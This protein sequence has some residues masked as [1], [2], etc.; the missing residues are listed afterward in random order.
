MKKLIFILIVGSLYGDT[1]VYR[2]DVL[3]FKR[4]KTLSDVSYV[5]VESLLGKP[6]IKILIFSNI[7]GEKHTWIPCDKILEL[8]N[9]NGSPIEY[10]CNELTIQSKS[11]NRA[12]MPSQIGGLLVAIGGGLLFSN[13][14]KECNDCDTLEDVE[15]FTDELKS[16]AKMGYGC[17]IVGGLL[18]TAGDSFA[19]KDN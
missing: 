5:G 11:N 8:N 9:D 17:I 18:I 7:L 1:V 6:N 14:D 4:T 13:L 3:M 10:D 12:I 16:T 2:N 19:D 15:D